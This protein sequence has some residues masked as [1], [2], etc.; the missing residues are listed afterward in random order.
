MDSHVD[1]PDLITQKKY[2]GYL[3]RQVVF[4][5]AH[6]CFSVEVSGRNEKI[7]GFCGF[8]GF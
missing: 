5:L 6:R 2:R 8:C 7:H 1:V 3:S 4:R